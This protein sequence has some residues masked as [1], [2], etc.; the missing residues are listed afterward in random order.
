MLENDVELFTYRK[1]PQSWREKFDFDA[2]EERDSKKEQVW[3]GIMALYLKD[4]TRSLRVTAL[5]PECARTC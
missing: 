2:T 1:A 3:A 5:R 4:P